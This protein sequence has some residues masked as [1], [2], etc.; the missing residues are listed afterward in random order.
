[1]TNTFNIDGRKIP[2]AEGQTVL[3][4]ARAAGIAI[5]SLCHHRKTG[6][7]GNCRLCVVEVEGMEGLQVSCRLPA[8]VGMTV[9]AHSEELLEVRRSLVKLLL[10]NGR[11]DCDSCEADGLCELQEAARLLGVEKPDFIIDRPYPPVDRSSPMIVKRPELCI[12]CGRCVAAC[13]EGVVHDILDFG[14]RGADRRVI[15]DEDLPLGKSDCVNC[16]EC[17]QLCPTGALLDKTASSRSLRTADP[18]DTLCPYCGVGCGITLHVDRRQGR[19]VGVTGTEGHPVS[20]G[21]LCVKGRYGLG[22][23]HSEERLDAPLRR[24]SDGSFRETSWEDA[25]TFFAARIQALRKSHGPDSIAGLSSAKCT[26]EENYLFQK[27]FRQVIGTHNVDHCAR[28]C[29]SS[30]VAGMAAAIGSGAMTNDIA[31]IGAADVILVIGSDTTAAHPVIASR[32]KQAV[33]SGK[34]KLI[35][36]DPKRIDLAEHAALY[37][38]QH[39]GSDVAVINGIMRLIIERGL[40]DKAFIER[41]CEGFDE[42]RKTVD[43]YPPERVREI[44]GVEEA[45]L[46]EVARLFGGAGTAAVF[47]AMGITQHTSGT[48]NVRSLVNLQLLCGNLGRAGGGVNPLRGQ[49]NV[50]GG[51][52]MGALPDYY[53][54]YRK[55]EDD[56]SRRYFEEAWEVNLPRKRGLT[57]MEM[58]DSA[59]RRSLR[60]MFIMGENPVLSDPDITHV[61]ESLGRLD[62]LVVQDIFL[63]ETARL[64]DLVLPAACFAE[65]EGLFTNTERRVQRLRRA[66]APP[67]G[68]LEDRLVLQKIAA[69]LGRDWPYRSAR[70]VQEEVRRLVPA[71]GGI[72]SERVGTVGL[73]WPCPSLEHPGTP[74]LH[75]DSFPVGRGLMK[76]VHWRPPA[77]LPDAEFPLVLTTGRLLCQFH[78]GTMTRRSPGLDDLAGPMVMISGR[79]AADLAIVDGESVEVTTRRGTI[80]APARI[81]SALPGGTIFVPFHFREAAANVLTNPVVDRVAGIPEFKVCAARIARVEDSAS[82]N[83]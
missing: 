8:A 53:P 21:M 59:S 27:L 60:A 3:E 29:H 13:R 71:Y 22:F 66:V 18:V 20:D 65:K 43:L 79:D 62:F 5:P 16:G 47:F 11:H 80:R 45:S 33:R 40:H 12:G 70:D 48:D 51:C 36:I 14:G 1:M 46:Q 35:V 2:F 38:R 24:R 67:G 55:V 75:G 26:N 52:D 83:F 10:S 9:R 74:I 54:G 68:A 25:I 61:R 64:A 63:T 19:V 73:Q 81:T 78:T 82:E 56:A 77:E 72:C 15:A 32:I 49:C 39:S 30:T 23:I 42:L 44:S 37:I 4:A 58:I 34:T 69:A 31:G 7:P 41:R 50:Q 57:V 28:L 17:V 6:A 76:G